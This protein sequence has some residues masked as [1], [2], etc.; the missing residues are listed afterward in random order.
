MLKGD[1]AWATHKRMLGW[2]IDTIDLT[3]TLPPHRL[4]RLC[5]V[6]AWLNPPRKRLPTPQWH[7]LLGELRSMSPALPGTRGLFSTLQEALGKGNKRR[8]R[9]NRHVWA[10]AADFLLLVDSLATRPTRLP[11]LVPT[12]PLAIGACDAC[13]V[14]MGGVWLSPDGTQPP[15]VWRHRFSAHIA[16]SLVTSQHR[17]G[18]ISISDLELAGIIGHK[19]V[20]SHHIDTRGYHL[21]STRYARACQCNA[22]SQLYAQ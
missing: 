18:T 1:A 17:N 15:V 5:E 20:I 9:I 21:Q 6:L 11:E 16:A 14:G 12:S 2:D 4:D 19:A 3:L 7:Q 8:V 13:Q 10:T 22:R